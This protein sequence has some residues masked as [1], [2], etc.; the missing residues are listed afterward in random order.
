MAVQHR[1]FAR[2]VFHVSATDYLE[3]MR[4]KN[5]QRQFKAFRPRQTKDV[6]PEAVEVAYLVGGET[7]HGQAVEEVSLQ[8]LPVNL[9]ILHP[10]IR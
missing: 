2:P 6:S 8:F 5:G 9:A 3:Q 4:S 7:S 10:C 1:G